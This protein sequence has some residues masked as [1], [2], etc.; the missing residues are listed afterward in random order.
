[1]TIGGYDSSR[2][3]GPVHTYGLAADKN[4]FGVRVVDI[5]LNKPDGSNQ[6]LI[7]Q[8]MTGFDAKI[9]TDQ[10]PM[11]FPSAV[12]NNFVN[13]LGASPSDN[14]DGSLQLSSPFQGSM[15]IVLSDG[16]SVTLP[17]ETVSNASNLTPVQASSGNGDDSSPFLL[18]TAWLSQVYLVAD[19]DAQKFH[20][21]Q[22]VQ[23]APYI[24]QTS[25]CK[26]STPAPYKTSFSGFASA[27]LVGAI[28]G[29]IIGF[30]WICVIALCVLSCFR[31]RRQRKAFDEMEMGTVGLTKGKGVRNDDE[32][33]SSM[34]SSE[35]EEGKS[36]RQKRSWFP[37]FWRRG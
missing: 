34:N 3:T 18:S 20:L 27:G 32:D 36:G 25:L 14:P 11:R 28:V 21:S 26:N 4:P 16:F 5:F 30:G 23:T 29:G 17:S 8:G 12:T 35:A 37:M 33:A 7:P 31:R 6:S 2:L 24:T 9:S 22:A 10:Y 15:T 19:Y 13:A 1:L